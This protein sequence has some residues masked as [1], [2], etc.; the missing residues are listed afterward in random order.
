M[1]QYEQDTGYGFQDGS[2]S[3]AWGYFRTA[4]GGDCV[5]QH[6]AHALGLKNDNIACG[7]SIDKLAE[8]DMFST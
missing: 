6:I 8:T 1:W 4:Y 5:K 7:S 3:T 2:G